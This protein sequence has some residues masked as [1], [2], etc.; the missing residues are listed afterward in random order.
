M[1][2]SDEKNEM[3]NSDASVYSGTILKLWSP[4]SVIY[5]YS[6]YHCIWAHG[7]KIKYLFKA[8]YENSSPLHSLSP[9]QR[10][11]YWPLCCS[12]LILISFFLN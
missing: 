11:P 7:L 8:C 5:L 6:R 2:D 9:L 12:I 1:I 4:G 10:K 3:P